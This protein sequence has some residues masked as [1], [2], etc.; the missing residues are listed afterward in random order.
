MNKESISVIMGAHNID[1][2]LDIAIKSI[3]ELL[4][5]HHKNSFL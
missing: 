4:F 5:F 2:F 1:K 3:L